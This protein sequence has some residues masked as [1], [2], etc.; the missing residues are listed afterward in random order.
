MSIST[1]MITYMDKISLVRGV[2]CN[3]MK[4][5]QVCRSKYLPNF[6]S[7]LKLTSLQRIN[8]LFPGQI[9]VNNDQQLLVAAL[10][11]GTVS[12]KYVDIYATYLEYLYMQINKAAS[13]TLNTQETIHVC[14]SRWQ[15]AN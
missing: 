6:A 3:Y 14:S 5:H 15:E 10:K 13:A 2:S 1:Y 4:Y 12:G 9:Q 11:P 8:Y 7:R